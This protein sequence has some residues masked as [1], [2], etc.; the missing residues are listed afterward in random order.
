M[1]EV[2]REFKEK[3][4]RL[5]AENTLSW[6]RCG[7]RTEDAQWHKFSV[8]RTLVIREPLKDGDRLLDAGCG[9]GMFINEWMCDIGIPMVGVDVSP[10]MIA[11]ANA[12]RNPKRDVRFEVGSIQDMQYESEFTKVVCIGVLQCIRDLDGAIQACT[13]ALKQGGELI[14]VT[15]DIRSVDPSKKPDW[16]MLYDR[17]PNEL[18]AS[19]ERAGLKEVMQFGIDPEK[20]TLVHRVTRD[21][22]MVAKKV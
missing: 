12:M 22:V 16:Y 6:K 2:T 20:G 19:L 1:D 21:I 9:D 15:L 10:A 13:R 3:Y 4:D 5:A 11:I 8:V 18:R 17:H 7:Y 14:L